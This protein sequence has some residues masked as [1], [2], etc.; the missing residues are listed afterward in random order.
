MLYGPSNI[1]YCPSA[2]FYNLRPHTACSMFRRTWPMLHGTCCMVHGTCSTDHSM[3]HDPQSTVYGPWNMFHCTVRRS[4]SITLYG[5]SSTFSRPFNMLQSPKTS[6]VELHA[7]PWTGLEPFGG[8]RSRPTHSTQ[9]WALECK[10]M[11]L[12]CVADDRKWSIVHRSCCEVH[13][14]CSMAHRTVTILH[15]KCLVSYGAQHVL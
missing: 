2:M 4:C 13:R 9:S 14:T 7:H 5:P 6:S 3:F 12:K 8:S 1:L 15:R 10:F 11:F